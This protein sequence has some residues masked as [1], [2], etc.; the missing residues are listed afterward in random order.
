[1]SY[2][3]LMLDVA[4]LSLTSA[5]RDVLRQDY[6]GGLILFARNYQSRGQL[7]DLIADIREQNKKIVIAVDQEGGR[8]QRFR[9]EFVLLPP[10]E[11]L[12]VSYQKDSVLALEQATELGWLMATELTGMDIDISFAPVLDLHWAQ[13]KVIGNRSFGA[14]HKQVAALATCFIKGMRAAG[15]CATGKHFPGHGW[16]VADSHIE[17]AI[18]DRPFASI[19][20]NDMQPFIA[21]IESGLDAVMPAHVI[22]SQ[23]DSKPAGFSKIWLQHILR[24]KLKFEGVVFSDDLNMSGANVISE[25][26][27]LPFSARA[28]AALDAGCDT[29]L[30][31]NNPDGARQVL[32]YL[33]DNNI[34]KS[35]RLGKMRRHIK[36]SDSDRFARAERIAANLCDLC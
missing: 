11:S 19:E 15:M 14:S 18:D 7:A 30:V 10:M 2:G 17:V 26:V 33:V 36:A 34:D 20:Q 22:Y 4:G 6:V 5:E 29:V 8:V 12:H 31:C 23:V 24:T 28:A 9:E 35:H 32:E 3:R 21:L 27:Q 13:S 16:A 25:G 1:M